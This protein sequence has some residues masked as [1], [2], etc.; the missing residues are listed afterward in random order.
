MTSKDGRISSS[1]L[2]VKHE[3]LYFAQHLH[4][5]LIRFLILSMV[6]RVVVSKLWLC[7]GFVLIIKLVWL[8][9]FKKV[10]KKDY[11]SQDRVGNLWPVFD[12]DFEDVM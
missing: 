9:K 8:P 4:D 11:E 1:S 2:S 3:Y 7:E 5:S 6:C 10:L 12:V